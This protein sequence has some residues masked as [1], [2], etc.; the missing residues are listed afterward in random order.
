MLTAQD[1]AVLPRSFI[2][3]VAVAR[4]LAVEPRLPGEIVGGDWPIEELRDQYRD[5]ERRHGR[6]LRGFIGDAGDR[7]G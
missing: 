6:M 1:R 5:L 2:V 7:V 3:S 4:F